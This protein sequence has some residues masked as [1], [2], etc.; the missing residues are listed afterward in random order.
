MPSVKGAQVSQTPLWGFQK[1]ARP[2]FCLPELPVIASS[3]PDPCPSLSLFVSGPR[4][5]LC[6]CASRSACHQYP[7]LACTTN[8]EA[9]WDSPSS[10]NKISCGSALKVGSC[11][12]TLPCSLP[13]A[14]ST[15]SWARLCSSWNLSLHCA[16]RAPG[17]LSLLLDAHLLFRPFPLILFSLYV[18]ASP[19]TV[20]L[21]FHWKPEVPDV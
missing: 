9:K 20:A 11:S 14:P 17:F 19:S 5:S 13:R 21:P 1:R 6:S 2:T 16:L 8:L 15:R 4:L 18:R 12:R 10:W 7:Y 3:H